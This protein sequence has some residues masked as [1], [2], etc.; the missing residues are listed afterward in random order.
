MAVRQLVER[1]GGSAKVARDLGLS[2]QA[3]Y[4]MM[5]RDQISEM[6]GWRMIH[7]YGDVVTREELGLPDLERAS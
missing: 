3:I 4:H 5:R 6:V 2:K 7:V 1:L